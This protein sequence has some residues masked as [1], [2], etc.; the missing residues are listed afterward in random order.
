MVVHLMSKHL[1][2]K[3]SFCAGLPSKSEIA[4]CENEAFVRDFPQKVKVGD[5]QKKLS[6]ETSLKKWKCKMCKR[7]FRARPP[8]ESESGRCGNEAFVRDFPQNLKVEDVETKLSCETSPKKWKLK[9]CKRSF[10]ARLPS[11]SASGRCGNEAFV[12]DF[13]QNLIS[14]LWDL[15]AVESSWLW[16]LSAVEI[17]WLWRSLGCGDLLAVRSLVCEISLL[18]RSLCCEI[19]LLWD[20]F[21]VR[22]L[23]CE[24]SWL[25]DLFAVRSLCCEI[26]WLWDLLARDS[27]D[28]DSGGCES[29]VCDSGDCD[30]SDC[31]VGDCD[32]VVVIVVIVLVVIVIVVVLMWCLW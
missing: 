27:G 22:S 16:D 1:M 32:V 9:M 25:W 6:C 12:R 31:D 28:C 20:L 23:G 18:W 24:I 4:K 30:V 26:S 15:S 19:S 14:W 5:V 17:S 3:R 11:K 2:S 7:S 29:G 8:S 10:R 13:L 21:A